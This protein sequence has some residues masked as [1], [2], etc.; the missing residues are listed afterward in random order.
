ML[1]ALCARIVVVSMRSLLLLGAGN[2]GFLSTDLRVKQS[3]QVRTSKTLAC[4]RPRAKTQAYTR[5][6]EH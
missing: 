2:S 1:S 3:L 5:I 4:S 6:I